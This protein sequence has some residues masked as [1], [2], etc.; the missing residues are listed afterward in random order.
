MGGILTEV[1]KESAVDLPPLNL[2]LARRLMERTRIYRIFQGY[3]NV[4]P[5]NLE[6]LAEILVRL[7]SW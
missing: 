5:A 2:L 6:E 7:P 4:P 3:R 1:L